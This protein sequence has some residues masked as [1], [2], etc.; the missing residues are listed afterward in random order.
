VESD[1][2]V[3]TGFGIREIAKRSHQRDIKGTLSFGAVT[4]GRLLKSFD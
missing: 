1:G 2:S 4:A 3:A